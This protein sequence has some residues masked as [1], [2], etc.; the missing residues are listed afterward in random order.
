MKTKNCHFIFAHI[1]RNKHARNLKLQV[2]KVVHHTKKEISNV[3]R[4][5]DFDLRNLS[6]V[7]IELESFTTIKRNSEHLMTTQLK[8]FTQS[9]ATN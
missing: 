3:S 4:T 2:Q 7:V 5:S 9:V 1:S 8:Y 6:I